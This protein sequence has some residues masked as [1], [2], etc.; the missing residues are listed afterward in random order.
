MCA[1]VCVSGEH[2]ETTR[3]PG[4]RRLV[5]SRGGISVRDVWVAGG[6]VCVCVWRGGI[7][8]QRVRVPPLS[9]NTLA[10]T[11]SFLAN[12]FASRWRR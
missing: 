10:V 5:A 12:G 7:S 9:N 4:K 11:C 6:I 1:R 2:G 8:L 3:N